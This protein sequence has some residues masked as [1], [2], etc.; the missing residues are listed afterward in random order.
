MRERETHSRRACDTKSLTRDTHLSAIL[1]H[2]KF[3]RVPDGWGYLEPFCE[4][5]E[6]VE[7]IIPV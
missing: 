2:E 5:R 1:D 7:E 3:R 4:G 6:A